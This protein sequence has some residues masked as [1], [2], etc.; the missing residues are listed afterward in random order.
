MQRVL[1]G[2]E[3]GGVW[4]QVFLMKSTVYQSTIA[5]TVL[6]KKSIFRRVQ[7]KSESAENGTEI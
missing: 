6:L 7:K 1:D 2:L 3:H 5:V 4:E